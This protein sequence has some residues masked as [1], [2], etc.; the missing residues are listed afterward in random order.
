MQNAHCCRFLNL[1]KTSLVWL[2]KYSLDVMS[3]HI[4]V[5]GIVIMLLAIAFSTN[6][7]AISANFSISLV[8]L[9]ITLVVI[10]PIILVVNRILKR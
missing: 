4:P 10:V 9:G 5:K 2:G 7:D 6:S 3:L 1:L 8:V